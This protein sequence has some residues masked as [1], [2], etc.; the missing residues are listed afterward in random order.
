MTT[1][2]INKSQS[3]LKRNIV[4]SVIFIA[5]GI[6]LTTK[7]ANDSTDFNETIVVGVGVLL[8]VVFLLVIILSMK[9]LNNF[10]G[11]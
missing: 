1:P 8:I 5:L 4:L 6:Y 7:K 3:K 10:K 11:K 9:K 2:E